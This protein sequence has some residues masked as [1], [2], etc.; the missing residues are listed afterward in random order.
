M[1]KTLEASEML[2]WREIQ[3]TPWTV[4][5]R[6]D[7]VFSENFLDMLWD[8]KVGKFGNN[9]YKESRQEKISKRHEKRNAFE[10]IGNI[11]DNTLKKHDH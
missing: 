10:L 8:A 4:R 6:I 3:Q 1:I 2:F 9:R 11:K 7:A 5:K